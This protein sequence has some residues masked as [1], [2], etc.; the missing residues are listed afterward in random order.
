MLFRSDDL[1]ASGKNAVNDVREA[2]KLIS[3]GGGGQA[4]MATA[5]GKD[6]SELDTAL[7]NMIEK[8]LK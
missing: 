2:A 6:I 3:G 1:V 7:G 4:G 5:G 8:A